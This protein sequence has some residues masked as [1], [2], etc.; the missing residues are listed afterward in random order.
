MGPEG[1]GRAFFSLRSKNPREKLI[2]FA[3]GKLFKGQDATS[4]RAKPEVGGVD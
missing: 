3:T 1:F 2:Q 4:T